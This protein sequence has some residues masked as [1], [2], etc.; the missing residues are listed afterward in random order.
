MKKFT[1]LMSLILFTFITGSALSGCS[2]LEDKMIETKL[3][4]TSW[5]DDKPIL[6]DGNLCP[7]CFHLGPL[8]YDEMI[9]AL[10]EL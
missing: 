2:V 3:E 7:N 5:A 4:Q 10:R 1:I 9:L 6:L 8:T